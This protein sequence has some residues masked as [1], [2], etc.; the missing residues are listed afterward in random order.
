VLLVVAGEEGMVDIQGMQDLEELVEEGKEVELV[1]YRHLEI[2]G[3]PAAVMVVVDEKYDPKV[4]LGILFHVV[5]VAQQQ[6]FQD[7]RQ[8]TAET[9]VAHLFLWQ[10]L[11][12]PVTCPPLPFQ[13]PFDYE[14]QQ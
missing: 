10:T 5:E 6:L 2:E 9:A 3:I 8:D 1:L 11:L 14:T 7:P 12:F 13:H 4:V